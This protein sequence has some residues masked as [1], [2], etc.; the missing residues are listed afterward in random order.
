MDVGYL[1]TGP[2]RFVSDLRHRA[3]YQVGSLRVL[4]ARC[5]AWKRRFSCRPESSMVTVRFCSSASPCLCVRV[6]DTLSTHCVLSPQAVA[7]GRYMIAAIG[8]RDYFHARA[9][10]TVPAA[11]VTGLPLVTSGQVRSRHPGC[12]KD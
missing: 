11:L 10:S 6:C 1:R 5:G 7:E 12:F 9:T 3:Y 8:E 4:V 2:L